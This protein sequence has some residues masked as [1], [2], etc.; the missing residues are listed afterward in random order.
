MKIEKMIA[1]FVFRFFKIYLMLARLPNERFGNIGDGGQEENVSYLIFWNLKAKA[2]AHTQ[3]LKWIVSNKRVNSY[4]SPNLPVPLLYT[5][6]LGYYPF[7][8]KLLK[9]T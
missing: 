6:R 4:L 5:S 1:T 7:A 2:I 3:S 8:Q 9:T